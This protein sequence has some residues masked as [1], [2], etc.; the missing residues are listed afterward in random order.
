MA[1]YAIELTDDTALEAD[2]ARFVCEGKFIE[3]IPRR[4]AT[5]GR[6]PERILLNTSQVRSVHHTPI[7]FKGGWRLDGN[8][9]AYF[10]RTE[11]SI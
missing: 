2:D 1:R 9:D 7:G 8:K 10:T 4:A 11:G 6:E 3:L 5:T